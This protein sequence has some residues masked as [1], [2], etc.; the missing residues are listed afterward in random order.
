MYCTSEGKLFLIALLFAGINSPS[1][2]R[3]SLP[4]PEMHCSKQLGIKISESSLVK[5][6]CSP[7][8]LPGKQ[9]AEA[10]ELQCSKGNVLPT[11]LSPRE[12]RGKDLQK[13]NEIAR[14]STSQNGKTAI[15]S[16]NDFKNSYYFYKRR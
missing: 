14:Y 13:V 4:T 8:Q 2:L 16:T 7:Y 6:C 9:E 3:N 10:G 5:D 15:N 12:E 1:T 11:F